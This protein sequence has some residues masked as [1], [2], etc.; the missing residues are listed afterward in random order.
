M[1]SHTATLTPGVV[2]VGFLTAPTWH[3]D[4]AAAEFLFFRVL[5]M[6]FCVISSPSLQ[7]FPCAVLNCCSLPVIF[8]LCILSLGLR[9]QMDNGNTDSRM[10][11]RLKRQNPRN[12]ESSPVFRTTSGLNPFFL[13]L[14][15]GWGRSHPQRLRGTR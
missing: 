1:G 7:P 12:G 5:A 8:L 10:P 14:Q 15:V 2:H 11:R 6:N 4:L 3:H 9:M 13:S